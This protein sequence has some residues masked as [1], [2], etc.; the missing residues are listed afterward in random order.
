MYKIKYSGFIFFLIG[1]LNF[2]MHSQNFDQTRGMPFLRNYLPEE[3]HAHEQNFDML[4]AGNGI[5]YIAN[6][7]GILEFDGA[8]WNKIVSSSGMR[9]VSLAKDEK[10][11]IFAGGLFDFGYL[12]TSQKGET[13]FVSLVDKQTNLKN[14]GLIFK[15]ICNQNL[16][17][18][19]SENQI[20]VYD[21]KK[22][23]E[24]KVNGQLISAFSVKNKIYLFFNPENEKAKYSG[25]YQYLNGSFEK[26]NSPSGISLIDL[27]FMTPIG[28]EN[29]ILAGTSSQGLFILENNSLEL[30]KASSIDLIKKNR[31]TS[32]ARL[33]NS[34]FALGTQGGV[35]I[36]DN[37]GK[38]IQKIDQVSGLN[39]ESINALYLDKK[40]SLWMATNN[41]I[42]KAEVN[43]PLTYI[44][45]KKSGLEGKILGI[46]DFGDKIFF[47][48]DRGLFFLYGSAIH[49]IE[50]LN[51]P[52][53]G[54]LKISNSLFVA[55]S[56]GIFSVNGNKCG[57]Q[58]CDEFT[59]CI[60]GSAH[61]QTK[62]Y[63]G[64]TKKLGI[65]D[66]TGNGL[67]LKNTVGNIR[68]DV[69][70]IVEDKDGDLY[71]EVTPG[72]IYVYSPSSN[73]LKEIVKDEGILSLHLNKKGSDVFI[74]S[75]KGLFYVDK[76][77][78]ALKPYFL[79]PGDSST[80]KLW[81]HQ[82]YGLSGDNSI[83]TN[84]EQKELGILNND[85][86]KI[87]INKT[88]FLPL[89]DFSITSL[90][91]QK[92][93]AQIWAG[94]KDG[95]II[96]NQQVLF[97][98]TAYFKTIIRSIKLINNDSTV[99]VNQIRNRIDYSNNSLVF[100]FAAPVFPVIGEVKYR[101][102]LRGFDRDSSA[103]TMATNKEYTNL[104][105]G[106]YVFS[107][108]AQN[109]FGIKAGQAEYRFRILT[110]LYRQWWAFIIY[111]IA[112]AGLVRWY[113]L[114]RMRKTSAGKERLEGLVK[115]RTEEIERSKQKIEEQRDIAY[116]QKKEI[117]DSIS[118]AQRIQQAVL[119]STQY[120]EDIL[121]EHFILYRP[122]DIVSGDFYWMKKI[123]NY[124]AVVAADC[125]GHGVPGAFMSMLGSSFLNEIVTRRSLDNAAQILNRLRN[126]VKKSLHQEGKEGEQKDGMDIALIIIDSE[127]LE[128]QYAGAY[129]PLYILRANKN[130]DIT[131]ESIDIET[132]FEFIQ[133]K[134]DRQ[135]I[136]IHLN[137]RDF[138][139]HVFQLQNGDNL[140]SFSDGY[141][142]QFG[143]ETGE[144]FKHKRFRDL[145]LSIQGK[146]MGEQ[147]QILEK[148]FV[149]WKRDIAQIDDVLVMGIKI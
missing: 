136:G 17:Y 90:W 118:Y 142:D 14:I 46:Q 9:V 32:C 15:V 36:I 130:V 61:D 110:P 138:T 134:A 132:R 135:P 28:N 23:D 83:Y 86:H 89:A 140:Y 79:I 40:A 47:A 68:G 27:S 43:W 26:I 117:L 48:T 133:L 54:M 143:G 82:I 125:T 124:V 53:V 42:T 66:Y 97:D 114:W 127:T 106:D 65:Y 109:E 107:V 129:N 122:R 39:N 96:S 91:F 2:Q 92:E 72:K 29:K 85:G 56:R 1:V 44:D 123:N 77:T 45:N 21:G 120:V 59:F 6:F 121:L 94:G 87:S 102:Y 11:K 73:K 113:M 105:D 128:L 24:I 80:H 57:N 139:N 10:G 112:L 64:H 98:Y 37:Q 119:P 95:L 20:Y 55:T 137:E 31:L 70:Q 35:I 116:K 52:C 76:N 3:Y 33:N 18:F 5:M 22:L 13:S 8:Q 84:G 58:A 145:L 25:L 101:F 12:K 93:S 74:A 126:K 75:E 41:G 147:K 141:V 104:P 131:N 60:T 146:P 34:L 111:I 62:V 51:L 49:P 81:M 99:E 4:Q 78:T 50:N 71:L 115:E 148:A 67:K 38:I 69:V 103:W 88:P 16:T 63:T 144:K 30:F 100:N 149:R 108:D 7:A 19:I